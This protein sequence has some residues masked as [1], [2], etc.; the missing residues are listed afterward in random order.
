MEQSLEASTFNTSLINSQSFFNSLTGTLAAIFCLYCFRRQETTP[1]GYAIIGGAFFFSN[2]LLTETIN[3]YSNRKAKKEHEELKEKL[4]SSNIQVNEVLIEKIIR[5]FSDMTTTLKHHSY[6][7]S[8][9]RFDLKEVCNKLKPFQSLLALI[10]LDLGI[11]YEKVTQ[12]LTPLFHQIQNILNPPSPLEFTNAFTTKGFQPES[13]NFSNSFYGI[14]DEEY[15]SPEEYEEGEEEKTSHPLTFN[16]N[17]VEVDEPSLEDIAAKILSSEGIHVY[18]P[19]RFAMSGCKTLDQFKL[20][21]FWIRDS[22]SQLVRDDKIRDEFIESGKNL[23]VS[24]LE[25]VGGGI[26]DFI[27]AY[28]NFLD[29][30]QH[31]LE[32]AKRDVEKLPVRYLTLWDIF[33]EYTLIDAFE[34]LEKVPTSLQ[35]MLQWTPQSAKFTLVQTFVV[36]GLDEKIEESKKDN[37][38]FREKY[39]LALKVTNLLFLISLIF[40]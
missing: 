37:N 2:F 10:L 14:E 25:V 1:K 38:K 13:D 23:T 24:F 6:N 22:L 26:E 33:V 16:P 27:Q 18:K 31:N 11:P 4:A 20:H 30:L 21:T 35:S 7:T 28:N 5:A 34:Q 3:W 9:N 15:F 12:I 19:Q 39:L 8:S 29:F 40:S 17:Y 36:S 32:S